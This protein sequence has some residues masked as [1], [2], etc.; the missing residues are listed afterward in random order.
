MEDRSKKLDS[1]MDSVILNDEIY[2]LWN[3][4]LS[5]DNK[6]DHFLSEFIDV[7]YN[8]P[9]KVETKEPPEIRGY[10]IA[11]PWNG[12]LLNADIMFLSSNPGFDPIERFP[13]YHGGKGENIKFSF[14][15]KNNSK[16][17]WLSIKEVRD[18]FKNRFNKIPYTKSGVPSIYRDAGIQSSNIN[19]NDTAPIKPRGVRFWKIIA[20]M[21]EALLERT[22][23]DKN[24]EVASYKRE[25]F[26]HIVSMEIVPFKS[27]NESILNDKILDCCWKKYSSKIFNMSGASIVFLTGKKAQETFCRCVLKCNKYNRYNR[28]GHCNKCNGDVC[29]L[30][31]GEI[32]HYKNKK[33]VAI[34]HLSSHNTERSFLELKCIKKDTVVNELR[35]V[36]NKM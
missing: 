20:N 35:R 29:P 22:L 24:K 18:F 36:I 34:P 26:R 1:L 30:K 14:Y 8:C 7:Q 27:K 28:C 33:F 11:E 25:L 16:N 15:E 9:K 13:R 17:E 10:Q 21:T 31:T 23:E 3:T 4:R 12:D 6:P 2:E 19:N 5:V 32:L